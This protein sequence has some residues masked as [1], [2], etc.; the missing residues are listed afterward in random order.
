MTIK[1][2][3]HPVWQERKMRHKGNSPCTWPWRLLAPEPNYLDSKSEFS[4]SYPSPSSVKWNSSTLANL[5]L[6]PLIYDIQAGNVDGLKNWKDVR[7]RFTQ[8]S[9][10]GYKAGNTDKREICGPSGVTGAA[11]ALHFLTQLF[12]HNRILWI[13]KTPWF[14]PSGP[15]HL[16]VV[17]C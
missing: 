15:K 4:P 16:S 10:K 9:S 8:R 5:K 11:P 7:L 17:G 6:P 3:N 12:Q 13:P 2:R 1:P 14:W